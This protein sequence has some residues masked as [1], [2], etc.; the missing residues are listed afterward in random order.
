M[1]TRLTSEQVVAVKEGYAHEVKDDAPALG[2]PRGD[3]LVVEP[4]HGCVG[5]GP[6]VLHSGEFV[7][8]QA[9]PGAF[10]LTRGG[11]K[12]ESLLPLEA[13]ENVAGRVA[14][15]LRRGMR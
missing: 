4:V 2:L 11:G 15:V 13:R 7:R 1:S 6:N 3:W 8:L 5:D 14:M 10:P 9:E 12:A